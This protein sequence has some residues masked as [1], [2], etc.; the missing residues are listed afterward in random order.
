MGYYGSLTMDG[1]KICYFDEPKGRGTSCMD[2][3]AAYAY[4]RE[5]PCTFEKKQIEEVKKELVDTYCWTYSD[6]YDLERIDHLIKA[7]HN[8][9]RWFENNT[10]TLVARTEPVGGGGTGKVVRFYKPEDIEKTPTPEIT[11]VSSYWPSVSDEDIKTA[12][13]LAQVSIEELALNRRIPFE[14]VVNLEYGTLDDV[15]NIINIFKNYRKELNASIDRHLDVGLQVYSLL[16]NMDSGAVRSREGN[17]EFFDS[18]GTLVLKIENLHP[19]DFF[20]IVAL[21]DNYGCSYFGAGATLNNH[22]DLEKFKK[23]VANVKRRNPC[24]DDLLEHEERIMY[25]LSIGGGY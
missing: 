21:W 19:N 18:N 10:M 17:V 1:G 6:V 23:A 22:D 12:K 13:S 16:T 20:P 9:M 5:I 8:L 4:S 25:P 7:L 11:D 2:Y 24:I 3:A 15:L 14:D